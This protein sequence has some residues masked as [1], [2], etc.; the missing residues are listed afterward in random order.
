MNI[1]LPRP[2]SVSVTNTDPGSVELRDNFSGEQMVA[3]ALEAVKQ[4]SQ[5]EEILKLKEDLLMASI[6]AF[7]MMVQN[8]LK[9]IPH[10]AIDIAQCIIDRDILPETDEGQFATMLDNLR[11]LLK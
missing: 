8:G 11:E 10:D 3:Y 2:S 6:L 1:P 5:S 9:F 7:G 4:S